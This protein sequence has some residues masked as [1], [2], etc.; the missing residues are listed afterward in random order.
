MNIKHI[1]RNSVVLM[2][3]AMALTACDTEQDWDVD[4][5]YDRLFGTTDLSLTIYDTKVAVSFSKT[6]GAESY[7]F[8]VSTDSLYLDDVSSSSIVEVFTST[9]DTI[10]NLTGETKYYLRMRSIAEGKTSSKWVYYETSSGRRYFTTDAE[11]IFYSTTAADYDDTNITVNW[12]TSKDATSLVLY[13]G[14]EVLQT[15]TL[16]SADLAAGTYT[17]TDLN[18]TTTYTVEIYNGDTRRGTLSITTAVAMPSANYRVT[19]PDDTEYISQDM[20]DEYAEA[21]Q[22]AAGSTSNYSVTIAIPAGMTVGFHGISDTDGSNTNIKLPDGM[23]VTFFGLSGGE[24]P[25][26][27]AEKC[28]DISG[29]H[30]YVH[31]ENVQISDGGCQYLIN[32]SSA[33]TVADLEFKDVTITDL[34]RSLVRLQSSDTKVISKLTL[35]NV[36]IMS[37]G[38]GAYACL[39]FNSSAY[40]VSEIEIVNSTLTNLQHSLI[41]CSGA[42]VNTVTITDCTF[43]NIIGSGRYFCDA[44]GNSTDVTVSNCVFGKSY[45][46]DNSR[47]IR[48]AGTATMSNSYLSSDFTISSNAS[49]FGQATVLD[50]DAATLFADPTNGDFTLTTSLGAGDP[51]WYPADE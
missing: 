19:I 16:T 39:Y 31:F 42:T 20:I 11:Q 6:Q 15:V 49:A 23:S 13:K 26:I 25:V 33:C 21:A 40:T 46:T 48:T 5:S 43:Y 35:D 29:S 47:G 3:G 50:S 7:Q 38:S 36:Y 14:D 51:E 12:D 10:Y 22:E 37:Q 44:N 18:P 28:L 8:E 45:T 32:Q 41:A 2:A 24:T 4:S 17:F 27:N 9:P 1:L 30:A 34:S